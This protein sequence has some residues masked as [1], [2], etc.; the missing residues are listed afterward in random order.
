MQASTVAS[1][2]RDAQRPHIALFQ[3]SPTIYSKKARYAVSADE[4]RR[5]PTRDLLA[6]LSR[7]SEVPHE[8]CRAKIANAVGQNLEQTRL[9][10][11]S[12]II[13]GNPLV[14]IEEES[15]RSTPSKGAFMPEIPIIV[16]LIVVGLAVG[17][18]L[19]SGSTRISKKK[20][21]SASLAAGLL[22]SAYAYLLYSLTP[23]QTPTRP[24]GIPNAGSFPL[25][26][27]T[28]TSVTSFVAASFLAA[29]L[30][31][32]LVLGIAMAYSRRR[33]GEDLTEIPEQVT[34]E[35]PTPAPD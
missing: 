28:T 31:V 35:E 20:L 25:G 26:S 6:A 24:T 13:L 2:R 5:R 27:F 17:A 19:K 4:R 33:G 1:P 18:T 8:I 16:P 15:P 11:E 32:V 14:S 3:I 30:M 7:S 21:A 34:E 10:E 12:D 29:F 9:G 23:V 22:N